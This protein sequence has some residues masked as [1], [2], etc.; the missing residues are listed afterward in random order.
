MSGNLWE[1]KP[2]NLRSE[3]DLE[4]LG[5]ETTLD[6]EPLKYKV[7]AQD[8]VQ[9][10][11]EFGLGIKDH[12]YNIFVAGPPR[13]RKT[14][15]IEDYVRE[16]AAQEPCPPD[17]LYVHNFKNPERPQSMVLPTGQGRTLKTDMEELISNLKVHVPEVFE[18]E[19]YANRREAL[20]RQFTQSRNT[21]LQELDTKANQ[22]GFVL[23][24]SQTG[25]MLSLIH[26]SEPTRPY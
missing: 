3:C 20:V 17:Y 7:V 26:I 2:E 21:I 13:S 15:I 12:E 5:F 11:L 25:L 24:I 4:T 19:E 23:N 9:R 1:L 6:L 8:R 22:E 16:L 14:E 10:A 18:G